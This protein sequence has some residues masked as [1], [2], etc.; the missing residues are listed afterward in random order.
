MEVTSGELYY[1]NKGAALA[2]HSMSKELAL[3]SDASHQQERYNAKLSD[4]RRIRRTNRAVT[5]ERLSTDVWSAVTLLRIS[6]EKVVAQ[7]RRALAR[8]RRNVQDEVDAVD[9]TMMEWVLKYFAILRDELVDARMRLKGD[10]ELLTVLSRQAKMHRD[11]CSFSYRLSVETKDTVSLSAVAKDSSQYKRCRKAV[12]DSLGSNFTSKFIGYSEINVV[13]VYK[14]EHTLLSN[15]LQKAAAATDSAKVKGLFCSIS[16][17]EVHSVC[18]YGLHCQQVDG[19]PGKSNPLES[20]AGGLDAPGNRPLFSCPW[21]SVDSKHCQPTKSSPTGVASTSRPGD[22]TQA[23]RLADS[24]VVLEPRF[25]RSSAP[26]RLLQLSPEELMQGTYLALCRVLI[27][28]LRLIDEDISEDAVRESARLGYDALYSTT[29]EEYVL[30]KPDHILPEF[31][32]HI[33][34]VKGSDGAKAGA[35]SP[36][37]KAPTVR[38]DLTGVCRVPAALQMATPHPSEIRRVTASDAGIRTVADPAH[39]LM[40]NEA[41]EGASPHLQ[42][43]DE[44]WQRYLDGQN[45]GEGHGDDYDRAKRDAMILKQNLLLN[46]EKTAETFAAKQALMMRR[47]YAENKSIADAA[48]KGTIAARPAGSDPGRGEA[49]PTSPQRGDAVN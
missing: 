44:I 24:S 16:T 34:L 18:A 36:R 43:E 11:L 41:R 39:V 10:D 2:L 26:T 15:N 17:K 32:M 38:P 27:S 8:H 4:L 23:R 49:S 19:L 13:N 48:F 3:D 42:R 20:F 33:H 21:F 35:T 1:L 46:V 30:L 37:A 6:K 29:L 22:Y 31:I 5:S 25:S 14:L 40:Q 9:A 45:A 12:M 47:F 28:R 7:L